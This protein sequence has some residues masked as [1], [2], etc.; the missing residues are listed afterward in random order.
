MEGTK[1]KA[2]NMKYCRRCDT[3][4][5]VTEFYERGKRCRCIQCCKEDNDKSY[6]EK[7]KVICEY[8]GMQIYTGQLARHTRSKK[9]NDRLML[10]TAIKKMQNL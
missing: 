7:S 1:M 10:Y 9:H 8:C 2:N 6:K 4:K 5:N 3:I